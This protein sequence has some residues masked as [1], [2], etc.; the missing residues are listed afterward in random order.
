MGEDPSE[1][2]V[3]RVAMHR[4]SFVKRLVVGTA[5]AV[6]VVSSFDMRNLAMNVASGQ[7]NQT[8]P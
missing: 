4:R 2:I 1:E 6:P 8:S 7:T 5:F 3:N